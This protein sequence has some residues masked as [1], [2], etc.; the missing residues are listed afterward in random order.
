M[1]KRQI[2]SLSLTC[3]VLAT[4]I[5]GFDVGVAMACSGR[6][7][8]SGLSHGSSIGSG[9]VTVCVGSSDSTPGSS[10]TH[11]ITKTIT[12]PVV[13][14]PKPQAKPAK[15]PV[16]KPSKKPTIKP[17][18]VACPSKAQ[19]ASMP[20]SADAAQRWAK[21]A[22]SPKPAKVS[23]PRP[24]PKP[25]PKTRTIT[26]T[27]VITIENPGYSSS[28]SA[29]AQFVPNPLRASVYPT[30]AL[31]IGQEFRFSSDPTSHFVKQKV[32]GRLAEVHFVPLRI[33]WKFGDGTEISGADSSKSFSVAGQYSARAEVRY[34][35]SYRLLGETNWQPVQGSLLVK[36]NVLN[37][38]VGASS[39]EADTSARSAL[40]VGQ[41][42]ESKPDAFGCKN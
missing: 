6:A 33:D 22:C 27:E 19:I 8:G 37:V 41:D 16:L 28:A 40:L 10:S 9:S 38:S 23:Q 26:I 25:V 5:T 35:V 18:P 29:S 15:K 21:S 14:K 3:I 42:C 20:R 2:A 7:S 34:S 36:S 11:T 12:V 31:M 4:A 24:K 30:P 39:Q 17:K 32:L 13:A 1:R